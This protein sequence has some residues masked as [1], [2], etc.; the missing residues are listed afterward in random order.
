MHQFEYRRPTSIVEAFSAKA[1]VP[2][3]IFVAGGSDIFLLL[4]K[5][6]ITP[7]CLVSLRSVTELSGISQ[8][9]NQVRIGSCTTIREI[10][11]SELIQA[12]FPALH[13][14][15]SNLASAQIRNVATLGG[16]IVNASPGADTAAPLLI[17]D[18]RVNIVNS[19]LIVHTVPLNNFFKGP[20]QVYLEKNELV[21]EFI[22][23]IPEPNSG[24]AYLKF[25][26]RKAMDLA[27]VGVSVLITFAAD[28]SCQKIRIAFA[29]V[30]PTPM[31]A[32]KT[33]AFLEGKVFDESILTQAGEIAADEISPI[34]DLRGQAWH[35]IEVVKAYLK[36]ACKLAATRNQQ[37][38][39][40]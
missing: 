8:T 30:A 21:K 13:D 27:N 9:E 4:K 23:E 32:H 29:T 33:E 5:N 14:A 25:M 24:S 36:R 26:K 40:V 3:A 37:T 31:R 2:E 1:C 35:K 28:G 12:T 11:K 6:I 38:E 20:K 39:G 10:E 22:L 18:T 7:D 15:V 34:D 17:Y 16:N 19:Q